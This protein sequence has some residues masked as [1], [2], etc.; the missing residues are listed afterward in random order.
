[1]WQGNDGMPDD[2]TL[3]DKLLDRV[4]TMRM[5]FRLFLCLYITASLPLRAAFYPDWYVSAD[6]LEYAVLDALST[7]FFF[8]EIAGT[9]RR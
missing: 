2:Q 6:Y 9:Y 4:D 3:M 1:M 5:F 7:V 8:C